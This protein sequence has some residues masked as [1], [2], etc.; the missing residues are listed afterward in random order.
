MSFKRGVVKE[1]KKSRGRM[2][3]VVVQRRAR[4]IGFFRSG[5]RAKLIKSSAVILERL[6]MTSGEVRKF[7]VLRGYLLRRA[8][9]M[10]SSMRASSSGVIFLSFPVKRAATAFESDPS[11]K[12]SSTLERADCAA[13]D[14]LVAGL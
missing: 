1:L 12:T 9:R 7:M 3:M 14:F 6:S 10:R 13:S 2:R 4:W 8:S 5:A 11:K